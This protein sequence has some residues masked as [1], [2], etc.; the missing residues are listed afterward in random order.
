MC[1]S[2]MQNPVKSS[3]TGTMIFYLDCAKT[4]TVY[5]V[6]TNLEW[7]PIYHPPLVAN[8]PVRLCWFK[9]HTLNLKS[10][11]FV[12]VFYFHLISLSGPFYNV[13]SREHLSMCPL[14]TYHLNQFLSFFLIWS[15]FVDVKSFT[16][17]V[18][19]SVF[20]TKIR[21]CDKKNYSHI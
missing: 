4:S 15:C 7:S 17:I 8:Y 12:W 14:E 19:M 9:I 18:K 5:I 13:K 6:Y 11:L 3:T 10:F 20:V 2:W 16:L 21:P 1:L